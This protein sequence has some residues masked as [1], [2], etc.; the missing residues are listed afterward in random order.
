MLSELHYSKMANWLSKAKGKTSGENN[1]KKW[2]K[3]LC[4]L[5]TK[6][7]ATRQRTAVKTPGAG[8]KLEHDAQSP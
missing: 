5:L 4:T 2:I 8:E 3:D 1:W 6:T 7:K